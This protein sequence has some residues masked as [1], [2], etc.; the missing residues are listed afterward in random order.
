MGG[1]VNP[2]KSFGERLCLNIKPIKTLLHMFSEP[3]N[4]ETSNIC[5]MG[6][7]VGM[8]GNYEGV[9]YLVLICDMLKCSVTIA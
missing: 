5:S 9:L 2:C 1:E 6:I 3:H 7:F 8:N 4:T